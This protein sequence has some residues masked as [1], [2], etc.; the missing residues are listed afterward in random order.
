MSNSQIS[1]SWTLQHS[2]ESVLSFVQGMLTA[3]TSDNIQPLAILVAEAFGNT[4]AICQQTQM[5]VEKEAGKRHVSHVVKFL[6]AKVGY[7]ANDTAFQL[8][9]TSAG[10]RFMSLV[11][12]LLCTDD[13]LNAA[14]AIEIMINA[15]S[16]SDQLMPTVFQ[17]RDLINAL[18][19]KLRRLQFAESLAGWEHYMATHTSWPHC[20]LSLETHPGPEELAA[21]VGAFR[22]M[23]RIGDASNI[24]IRSG[25]HHAWIIAFTKWCLG[26]P[27]HVIAEDGTVLVGQTPSKVAMITQIHPS[28]AIEVF[29]AVQG[30]SELWRSLEGPLNHLHWN[31]LISVKA[32]GAR[33][34]RYYGLHTQQE[35]AT[36]A[37][38]LFTSTKL[39]TTRLI[40]VEGENTEDYKQFGANIWPSDLELHSTIASFCG[41]DYPL[42]EFPEDLPVSV[43]SLRTY[44][45][46]LVEKR[47]CRFDAPD[48]PMDK[49]C[50]VKSV[51]HAIVDMTTDILAIA[52]LDF[53]EDVRIVASR[54]TYSDSLS[55][56]IQSALYGP[57][58]SRD[59]QPRREHTLRDRK[60]SI[61]SIFDVSLSLLGHTSLSPGTGERRFKSRH[62]T[63]VAKAFDNNSA[64]H[65]VASASMG[66]VVY[67]AYFDSWNGPINS[68]PL[69]RLR[70][71]PGSILY[72]DRRYEYVAFHPYDTLILDE[73]DSHQDF[74][75]QTPLNLL[76]DRKV[77]WCIKE[78]DGFLSLGMGLTNSFTNL[79]PMRALQTA[80]FSLFIPACTHPP[81]NPLPNEQPYSGARF[82]T[83]F[84]AYLFSI[85]ESLPSISIVAVSEDESLRSFALSTGCPAV[86]RGSACLKCCVD[87]YLR[88]KDHCTHI[89]C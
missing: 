53:D 30:P 10:V 85:K 82:I 61:P 45:D 51:R 35:F 27:P 72:N 1:A 84:Y 76:W 68:L 47:T 44:E 18:D 22:S 13:I 64:S 29:R 21:L 38:V 39:A 48:N 59:D 77:Q 24:V 37:R 12:A 36:M 58:T 40:S 7:A 57:D 54:T 79:S 31:G 71:G 81:D 69:A 42:T 32:Y 70:V 80:C 60:V 88:N 25:R 63:F 83:P 86:V 20:Y 49:P 3:A 56:S 33:R 16:R 5:L 17:I 23:E 78:E 65:W 43:S 2:S 4:L 34:L 41:L 55:K 73:I 50:K 89:I 9:L 26:Y 66:Q 19:Y 46:R 8:S 6:H 62:P 28:L 52:V 15:T 74:P 14:R 67:P 87:I 11:A 75:C